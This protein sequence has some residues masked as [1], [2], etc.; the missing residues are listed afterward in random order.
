MQ[1]K[2][3]ELKIIEGLHNHELDHDHHNTNLHQ[4]DKPNNPGPCH[5]CNGPHF[6]IDCNETTC[7]RCKPNL[8]SH[9]PSEC[10]GDTSPTGPLTTTH[11]TKI[12]LETHMQLIATQNL[13]YNFWFQPTSQ[14]RWL[15]CWKPPK[16]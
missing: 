11:L 1:K 5:T 13:T 14:T 2:D 7:P 8:N 3:A 10:P 15:N 12:P 16:R 6:I 9:T 4:N